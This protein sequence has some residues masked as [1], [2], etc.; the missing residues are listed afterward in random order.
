MLHA[1][2]LKLAGNATFGSQFCPGSTAEYKCQTTEGSLLWE[3]S[4]TAAN[5]VFDNP[6]QSSKKLGIFLLQLDGI[7]ITNGT[8][9]AVNST[10]V[11]S[12]LQ[13]SHNGTTLKCSEDTDLSMFREAVLRVAGNIMAVSNRIYC[14]QCC[15]RHRVH[16]SEHNCG[17]LIVFIA[18]ALATRECAMMT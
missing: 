7:L 8:V 17:C 6:T 5:H 16:Y 10:A 3:T 1:V 14:I 13:L 9:L 12:N 15:G 18:S 11:V 4:T 2:A